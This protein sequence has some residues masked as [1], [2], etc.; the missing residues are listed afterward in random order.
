[1]SQ[2]FVIPTG[3]DRADGVTVLPVQPYGTGGTGGTLGTP[4]PSGAIITQTP[5]GN[6]ESTIE[7][8]V[9]SPEIER[10]EQ[11]TVSH[12]ITGDF[13]PLAFLQAAFGRG[14]FLQ[15]SF[16][17]VTRVLSNKLKSL[18]ADRGEFS[19][20]AESISFDSPPDEF[21][22]I[23]VELGIDIIKYPRYFYALYPSGSDFTD[24]VGV[25]P[26]QTTRAN[27]KQAIIRAIQTYR[28]SPYFPPSNAL[29]TLNSV[30]QN[31]TIQFFLQSL[32]PCTINSTNGSETTIDI[33]GDPSS[34]LAV[35]AAQEIIQKLWNQL[36]TPYIAGYQVTWTQ[37]FFQPVYENPGGY[38][39][40][41]VGI[42]P[43]YFFSPV[44][45]NSLARGW[46]YSPYGNLDTL[47]PTAGGAPTIFDFM[48]A[49]NP[50]CYSSD[51][52]PSGTVNI[53][54]L[55]KADEV[56]FE[57]TWFRVTR[58]W[59]GSPIGMWDRQIYS[60]GNRPSVPSDYLPLA[61]TS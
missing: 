19:Y 32:I 35:A 36:D 14:T 50:Q 5:A 34:L 26:N 4:T 39:E 27:V 18:R 60:Q 44:S 47:P 37:F 1:M 30:V 59:I 29:P 23:P 38:I 28:D 57:R 41:P 45:Q 22:M 11:G 9:T 15:D 21:Q 6:N 61:A 31:A 3:F 48:A 12:T 46:L 7:E 25:A 13:R 8:D 51:G 49:I 24:L 54:W 33:S 58:T 10:A 43:D 20:V 42:V 16:G 17:N 2:Q 40:D 53:S 52:T 55:R 56:V